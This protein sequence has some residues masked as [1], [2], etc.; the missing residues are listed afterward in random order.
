MHNTAWYQFMMEKIS[1][2]DMRKRNNESKNK[3]VK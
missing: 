3:K 1:A 2:N